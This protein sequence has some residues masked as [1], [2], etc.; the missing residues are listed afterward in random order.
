VLYVPPM[1]PS[2]IKY[3]NPHTTGWIRQTV[4]LSLQLWQISMA[5]YLPTIFC[6]HIRA[7]SWLFQAHA[8]YSFVLF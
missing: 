8:D 1:M 6:W 7:C 3:N 4:K 2:F 5:T